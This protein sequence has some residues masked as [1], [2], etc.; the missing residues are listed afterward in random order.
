VTAQDRSP[1]TVL[2]HLYRASQAARQFMRSTLAESGLSGDEYGF[3]S[4]L[5][6]AGPQPMTAIAREFD[7]PV[8]TVAGILAGPIERG[9]I[10]R[11]STSRDARLRPLALT[12]DGL[13]VHAQA[14]ATYHRAYDELE[15]RL[16]DS[17]V[18]VPVLSA[19]L[20]ELT[21]LLRVMN[22]ALRNPRT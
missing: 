16:V 19:E 8:T 3:M 9:E 17:G 20:D 1:Y 11:Q 15:R 4:Y 5:F 6:A 21:A 22:E 10:T 2:Y 7:L 18:E 12:E 14:M 13:R